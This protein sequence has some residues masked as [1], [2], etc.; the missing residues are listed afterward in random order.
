MSKP[1]LQ[2]GTAAARATLLIDV[3][4]DGEPD[5]DL[6]RSAVDDADALVRPVVA[7]LT[8]AAVGETLDEG[9]GRLAF[10]GVHVLAAAGRT[11]LWRPLLACLRLPDEE[12]D[13]LFGDAVTETLPAV[14]MAVFDGDAA[15]AA[16]LLADTGVNGMARWGVAEVLAELAIAGRLERPVAIDALRAFAGAIG[17][18]DSAWLGWHE[19]VLRLR[20]A[21][22]VPL[23]RSLWE[24]PDSDLFSSGADDFRADFAVLEADPASPPP[25]T[26]E[27]IAALTDPTVALAFTSTE[28]PA[29]DAALDDDEVVW[30]AE[31]L[32]APACRPTTM[33]LEMLDGFLTGLVVGPGGLDL[34]EVVSEILDGGFRPGAKVSRAD[35]KRF[36]EL[37][38]RQLTAIDLR[39]AAGY[40]LQPFLF[41]Q[42]VVAEVAREA[43]EDGDVFVGE[44]WAAGFSAAVRLFDR[45][46]KR[47]MEESEEIVDL[48]FPITALAAPP[49]HRAEGGV[50]VE[51]LQGA[52][53]LF[54][55]ATAGLYEHWRTVEA[56]REATRQVPARSA[57][58]GRNEPCPCGSGK[59]YKRCCGAAA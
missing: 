1:P 14:L 46:W 2:P 18:D 22:L 19:A 45:D 28:D 4:R 15:P 16:D 38:E 35:R 7:V 44:P 6:L 21:E 11:E 34:E 50:T 27:P 3:L 33:N 55:A 59:K 52:A 32:I 51:V 57:K 31:F 41:P 26:I 43:G 56:E 20:A 23:A 58:V 47:A 30:L 8:A 25:D 13:A 5:E 40:P 36:E 49:E 53:E 37:I 54:P 39:L 17:G 48:L 10:H 12:L 42:E 24:Q 29:A 9:S